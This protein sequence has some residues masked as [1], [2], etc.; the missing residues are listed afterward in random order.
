MCPRNR[1]VLF[2][3]KLGIG[4]LAAIFGGVVDMAFPHASRV[5]VGYQSYD[6][7]L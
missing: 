6:P 5:S 7:V 4:E 3:F 1:V 2:E